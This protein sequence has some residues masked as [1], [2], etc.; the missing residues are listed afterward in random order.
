[1]L[2]DLIQQAQIGRARA[3][4]EA[5][6]SAAANAKSESQF[7][8]ARLQSLEETVERLSLVTMALSELLRDRSLVTDAE[9]EA[10]VQEID[11][12]DGKLDGRLRPPPSE[13]VDCHRPNVA[14]R[15]RCLYC[16]GEMSAG[17]A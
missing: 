4:A 10:R 2:W 13:C 3:D 5:A 9:V 7:F 12:R 8:R 15:K 1:M 6:K 17:P 11:L 14:G 16:G